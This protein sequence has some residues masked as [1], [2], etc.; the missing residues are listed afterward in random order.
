MH[1]GSAHGSASYNTTLRIPEDQLQCVNVAK[2]ILELGCVISRIEM[3]HE[4]G[5]VTGFT[6]TGLAQEP[7]Y[8]G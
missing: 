1:M 7:G 4:V 3:C 2:Q 8:N 6:L 5:V